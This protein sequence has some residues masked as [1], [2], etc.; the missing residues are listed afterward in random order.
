MISGAYAL[1]LWLLV[2][3]LGRSSRAGQ[4]AKSVDLFSIFAHLLVGSNQGI[5]G[6]FM[7]ATKGWVRLVVWPTGTGASGEGISKGYVS[8][9]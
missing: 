6:P 4:E 1:D 3:M 5:P 7:A 9:D 2:E 8:I